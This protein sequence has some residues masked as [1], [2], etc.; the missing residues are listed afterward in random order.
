MGPFLSLSRI[1]EKFGMSTRGDKR[2]NDVVHTYTLANLRV[3]VN[4]EEINCIAR[5][6]RFDSKLRF[7]E[8]HPLRD[9]D[10]I[11]GR[12]VGVNNWVIRNLSGQ[13]DVLNAG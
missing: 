2:R 8:V 12:S 3:G 5:S 11:N 7:L 6:W 1:E 13:R 4:S 10:L 9:S